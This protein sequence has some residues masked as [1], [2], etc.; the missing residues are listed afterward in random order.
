LQL[1][2][3]KFDKARIRVEGVIRKAREGEALE[4]V[5]LMCDLLVQRISLI[6]SE[7]A[8]PL[9]LKECIHTLIWAAPRSHVEELRVVREQLAYKYGDAVAAAASRGEGEGCAVNEKV[10]A[11]LT[12][13]SSIALPCNAVA[14]LSAGAGRDSTL[15]T[16][17]P[18][19]Q[20]RHLTR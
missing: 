14:S 6:A 13:R 16:R 9:D 17:A 5:E 12:V 4:V 1:R 15:I 10:R 11:R 3:K 20:T 8:L 7:K 2:D 19:R 18:C